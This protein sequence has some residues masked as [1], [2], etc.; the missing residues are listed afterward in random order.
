MVDMLQAIQ[1]DIARGW[2]CGASGGFRVRRLAI[3]VPV[4]VPL[5]VQVALVIIMAE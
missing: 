1:V 2:A 3:N 4:P 5:A